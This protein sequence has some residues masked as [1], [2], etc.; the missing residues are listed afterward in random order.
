MPGWTS[1]WLIGLRWRQIALAPDVGSQQPQFL[2]P[3][4]PVPAQASNW[5]VRLCSSRLQVCPVMS[6]LSL[7]VALSYSFGQRW[8]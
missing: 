8:Q 1:G 2:L 5:C 7:D 6:P 3:M 4:P